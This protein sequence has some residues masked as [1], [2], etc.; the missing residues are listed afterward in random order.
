[1]NP[2]QLSA[3]D[4]LYVAYLVAFGG[5][6]LA[7]F[8]S[9]SR[10]RQISDRDTR[11]GL[12]ALLVTSGAWAL[13]HAGFIAASDAELKLAFYLAGLIVGFAT[14]GPWLYF[15]SAY[16]GRSL[17]RNRTVQ[18]LA[19]AVFLAVVAVKMTN[20]IHQL[21]FTATFVP[22][23]FPHLAIQSTLLHWVIMGLSYTLA[24]IGYFM[25]FELFV[26]VDSDATPLAVLVTLTGLPVLLDVA[27]LASTTLLAIPYEPIGV[28]A[29]AL[30]VSFVYLDRFQSIQLAAGHDDP[31]VVLDDDDRIR[32]YNWG[33]SD[34]FP[35]LTDGIGDPLADVLPEIADV[36]ADEA[37]VLAFDRPGGTRYYHVSTNPFSAD[38]VS[39]GRLLVFAD[40]THRER[41]RRELERQNERLERFASVVSHDLR[42]PLTVA[43]GR[44]QILREERDDDHLAVVDDALARMETLIDD[45]LSLARQGEPVDDPSPVALEPIATQAWGMVQSEGADLVVESDADLLADPDRLQQLFENL[46]RNSLEHGDSSTVRVGRLDDGPGFFVADDGTGIPAADREEIFEFGYT[47]VEDGTGFGLAIVAEIVDAHG[48]EIAVTESEDG[49]ARFEV[50]A[51]RRP[52]R[53][54][55]DD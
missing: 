34:L 2:L 13:A 1:V 44:V 7:C 18:A 37:P 49:G 46:F 41:Y 9:V 16:T 36:L 33:A 12:V 43:S 4:P 39:T 20:P 40:V 5:A 14:V 55:S 53:V 45:L 10:L 51:S 19:V 8:A 3:L 21:Y 42:N 52:G 27:S 17:H 24:G 15:C 32:D 23:P 38:S 35:A 6:A 47:T 30:G 25:L 26:Q 11:R 28:A 31:V 29:F 22:E 54:G 50:A 48:W